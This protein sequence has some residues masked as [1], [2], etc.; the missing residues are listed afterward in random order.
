MTEPLHSR[1]DSVVCG[2]AIRQGDRV[3]PRRVHVGVVGGD[4]ALLG[5][6]TFLLEV[7]A[8][9]SLASAAEVLVRLAALP[10]VDEHGGESG[11]VEVWL[12]CEGVEERRRR[13]GSVQ[14]RDRERQVFGTVDV[15]EE[16]AHAGVYRL[17]IAP[18]AAI[19]PHHHQVMQEHE[20][21]MDPGLLRCGEPVAPGDRRSW[22]HGLVHDYVNTSDAWASVLCVD[23]PPFIPSDEVLAQGADAAGPAEH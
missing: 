10:P 16:L 17:N 7:C 23:L 3:V 20:R 15:I 4:E 21:V 6:L 22:P 8:F 5:H 13:D 18:G 9:R 11:P 1:E 2:I 19:P 12:R 14:P